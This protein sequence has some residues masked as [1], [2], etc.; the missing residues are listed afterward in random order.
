MVCAQ[1]RRIDKKKFP[2]LREQG[3]EA[4]MNLVRFIAYKKKER[5]KEGE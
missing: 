2:E 3:D 5:A 1:V 4:V